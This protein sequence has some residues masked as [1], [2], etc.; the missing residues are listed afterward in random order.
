MA[1]SRLIIFPLIFR[2]GVVLLDP[3]FR[4]QRR[5]AGDCPEG[6]NN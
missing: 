1:P 4:T 3:A 6:E 5:F 2:G